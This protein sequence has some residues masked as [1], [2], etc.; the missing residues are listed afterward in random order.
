MEKRNALPRFPGLILPVEKELA[1]Q[2]QK[3]KNNEKKLRRDTRKTLTKM[4]KLVRQ[5]QNDVY[6]F[7]KA[8]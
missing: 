4:L 5:R 6:F 8:N 7:C 1:D 2:R 3:K